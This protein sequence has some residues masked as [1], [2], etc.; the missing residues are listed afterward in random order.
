MVVDGLGLPS[1]EVVVEPL[2]VV[3]VFEPEVEVLEKPV[4]VEVAGVEVPMGGSHTSTISP[5]SVENEFML[6]K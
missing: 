2:I 6:S 3:V 1:L 5:T 4:S